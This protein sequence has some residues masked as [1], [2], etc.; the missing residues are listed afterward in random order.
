LTL[1]SITLVA[2]LLRYEKVML[3][4]VDDPVMLAPLA[5]QL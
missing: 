3:A 1:K 5:L 2:G 4:P